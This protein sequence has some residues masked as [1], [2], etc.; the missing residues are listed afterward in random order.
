M[1]GQIG[2]KDFSKNIMGQMVYFQVISMQKSIWLWV[3]TS[4][5]MKSLAVAML[6]RFVSMWI[7]WVT[8][9]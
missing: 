2:V 5:S 8:K 9:Y 4:V 6:T 7:V 3:G 1:A